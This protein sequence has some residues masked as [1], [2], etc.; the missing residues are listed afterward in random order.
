MH[1]FGITSGYGKCTTQYYIDERNLYGN[2]HKKWHFCQ[3]HPFTSARKNMKNEL[4]SEKKI[5]STPDSHQGQKIP[6]DQTQNGS[7][8]DSHESDDRTQNRSGSDSPRLGDQAQNGSGSDSHESGDQGIVLT[9]AQ[10][11]TH[12]KMMRLSNTY[13]LRRERLR[14]QSEAEARQKKM[15]QEQDALGNSARS[16]STEA[17]YMSRVRGLFMRSTDLRSSDPQVPVNPNAIKLSET[18]VK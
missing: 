11:K 18:V 3:N 1:A 2:V 4:F 15:W 8:S 14:I 16:K 5:H 9:S 13:A 10:I 6:D 17:Q 7:G 12:E